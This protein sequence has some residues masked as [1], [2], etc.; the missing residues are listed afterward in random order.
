MKAF[1]CTGTVCACGSAHVELQAC[2]I[3][4]VRTSVSVVFACADQHTSVNTC[5]MECV[6]TPAYVHMC[7]CLSDCEMNRPQ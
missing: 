5:V 4:T 6:G 1:E 2:D 3:A 7:V